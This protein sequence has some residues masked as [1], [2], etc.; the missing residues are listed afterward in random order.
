MRAR[1]DFMIAGSEVERYHT[2]RTI[3]RETVGH[4]SHGVAMFVLMMYEGDSEVS[5]WALHQALFHDLAEHLLGDIPAPAKR[6]YGIGAQV[7]KEETRL[8][9]AYGFERI[10]TERGERR[11]KLAD[12]FQGMVFCIREIELGN[13][14]MRVVYHRYK[15]YADSLLPVGKEQEV[16][17]ALHE[18]Y[19]EAL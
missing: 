11:L 1:I 3:Q 9:S 6:A 19:M 2:V 17:D 5:E 16:Y 7:Q 15:S 14:A 10:L 18:R 13:K 4:H 12:I 8:L